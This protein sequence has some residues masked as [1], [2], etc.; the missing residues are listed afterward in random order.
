[1]LDYQKP[2]KNHTRFKTAL[3]ALVLIL[4]LAASAAIYGYSKLNTPRTQL[5]HEKTFTV[6]T[7]EPTRDIAS[8]LE[9]QGIIGSALVFRL[10]AALTGQAAKIQA[11]T[12]KLDSSMT[13]KEILQILTLGRS[14]GNEV[15]ITFPE[16]LTVDEYAD[17]IERSGLVSAQSFLKAQASLTNTDDYS[18]LA[19]RPHGRDLEGYLFPDTYDFRRG[20]TSDEVLRVILK[21]F[22]RKLSS[23]LR[24]E[25]TRQGKTVF[26]TI[27]LA[28]IIEGEVGRNYKPGTNLTQEDFARLSTERGLVAGVFANR[29]KANI[30]LQSDATL[31]YVTGRTGERATIE[32]TKI[33]SPYNTYRF[34]GL[35]PGPINNPSLDS[36]K[37]AIYPARTDYMYFLSKPDGEAVF[38]KTLEEHNENKAKYLK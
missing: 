1:M 27:T 6:R 25:I 26:D 37:A 11:G 38:S 14:T 34:R 13:A 23:D 17:R 35:P 29:L 28:S 8:E 12:F 36:I 15:R 5:S 10:Y 9:D 2:R 20:A 31:A 3:L 19:D 32:D 33:N 16:G 4:L 22:D 7:G 24:D 30:A 18:F 21:N